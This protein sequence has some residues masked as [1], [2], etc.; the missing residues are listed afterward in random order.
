[1]KAGR[2]NRSERT[3]EEIVSAG[4]RYSFS[5]NLF[6]YPRTCSVGFGYQGSSREKNY[7]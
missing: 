7:T 6:Y 4:L 1:M 5:L 2:D 3:E